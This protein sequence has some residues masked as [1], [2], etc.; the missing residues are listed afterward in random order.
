[1]T[2]ARSARPSS[3]DLRFSFSPIDE[4]NFAA[5]TPIAVAAPKAPG[6]AESL[7]LHNLTAGVTY[8]FAIK[9][10]DEWPLTSAISNVLAVAMP[11]PDPFGPNAIA[12]LQVTGMQ[13]QRCLSPL[14]RSCRCG[15][16]RCSSLRDPLQQDP[17]R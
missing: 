4:S 15:L 17:D 16:R 1:M 8:Y 9:V 3:Y 11:P 2:T 5:A 13:Q 10:T 14:D 7:E 6:S 12:D